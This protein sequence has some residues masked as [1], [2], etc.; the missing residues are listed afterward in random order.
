VL[1]ITV[2][3]FAAVASM[4]SL[5]RVEFHAK[6]PVA[7]LSS[8]TVD[9]LPSQKRPAGNVSELDYKNTTGAVFNMPVPTIPES[10]L[11]KQMVKKIHWENWLIPCSS[12]MVVKTVIF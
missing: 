2:V 4:S 6:Q 3:N 7:R 1:G 12:K 11:P 10:C 9:K 8:S 5:S